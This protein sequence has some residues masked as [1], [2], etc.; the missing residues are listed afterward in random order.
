[1][2]ARAQGALRLAAVVVA[3]VLVLAAA[4]E[5]GARIWLR[6]RGRPLDRESRRAFVASVCEEM[7]NHGEVADDL[8]PLGSRPDPE[9]GLVLEP[10]VAWSDAAT[11]RRK[12]DDAEAYARED[13]RSA[14][15]VVL[16]GGSLASDLGTS[17]VLAETLRADS[18]CG[19]RELRLHV[20]AEPGF[21]EPQSMILLGELFA[22]GHEPD[23]VL[24]VDGREE[25]RTGASNAAGGTHPLFP[26]VEHWARAS[27]GMRTDW[28][29]ARKIHDVQAARD[30]AR[31]FG[32]RFLAL[33]LDRSAFLGHFA[34]GRLAVLRERAV[35]DGRELVDYVAG[36][37]RDAEL[38]GPRFDRSA[39]S[40]A[41]TIAG[42]W[43]RAVRQMHAL[44]AARGIDFL[45][46]L[47]PIPA[48]EECR[49]VEELRSAADRLR[50]SGVPIEDAS[51]MQ[52]D[53]VADHGASESG[54]Q[55]LASAI[56]AGLARPS[57]RGR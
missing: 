15:D 35:R 19:G 5:I 18:R 42:G 48:A 47:E 39:E 31:V 4:L 9:R 45:A 25:A 38:E 10:Y 13:G 27:R 17:P 56:A 52:I 22:L 46:V 55:I 54:S 28:T 1:M 44:C 24:A 2:T 30:A 41:A 37:P 50:A 7:T 6:A 43:E 16:L 20:Y 34:L 11:E 14:F 36:R 29:L 33:G 40:V 8:A 23:L 12:I 49:A 51:R 3:A 26:S 32:Q 21:K 53:G 57:I